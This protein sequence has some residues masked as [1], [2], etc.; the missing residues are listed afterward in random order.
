[1]GSGAF[2]KVY[3]AEVKE[4]GEIVAVKQILEDENMMNRET[5]ILQMIKNH[6]SL[7][8]LR[9]FFYTANPATVNGE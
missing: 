3:K 6:K 7:L 1:M 4:T 8:N 5:Q 9:D 2:G